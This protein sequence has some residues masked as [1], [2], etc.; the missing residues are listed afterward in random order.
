MLNQTTKEECHAR[1]TAVTA[2]YSINT[3][4]GLFPQFQCHTATHCCL[5]SSCTHC[6]SQHSYGCESDTHCVVGMFPPMLWSAVLHVCSSRDGCRVDSQQ[7]QPLAKSDCRLPAH[8]KI[9]GGCIW[10]CPLS[11]AQLTQPAATE[12]ASCSWWSPSS[13]GQPEYT[14]VLAAC[15]CCTPECSPVVRHKWHRLQYHILAYYRFIGMYD[16]VMVDW[17]MISCGTF[18]RLTGMYV[19]TSFLMKGL[20]LID[21]LLVGT[22]HDKCMHI[23]KL[24]LITC[25]YYL[26]LAYYLVASSTD[27]ACWVIS[28][29]VS[30]YIWSCKAHCVLNKTY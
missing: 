5:Y 21:D 22:A 12:M 14:W 30:T 27:H 25:K 16:W 15:S 26:L 13:M 4:A 1:V 3:H 17:V 8:G 6:I 23:H 18:V 24:L 10:W 2:M 19:C 20:F 11:V 7:W 9:F 29:C 28:E